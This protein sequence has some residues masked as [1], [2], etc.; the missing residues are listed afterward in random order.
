MTPQVSGPSGSACQGLRDVGSCRR[1]RQLARHR[2][3]RK[4]FLWQSPAEDVQ[5]LLR[6]HLALKIHSFFPRHLHFSDFPKVVH[7]CSVCLSGASPIKS[8]LSRYLAALQPL[9]QQSPGNLTQGC[10]RERDWASL[11]PQGADWY[12]DLRLPVLTCRKLPCISLTIDD[13]GF[14]TN[15]IYVASIVQVSTYRLKYWQ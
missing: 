11:G 6:A 12:T 13:L 5:M 3:W 10:R 9:Q 1:G 7:L 15:Y 4:G 8:V 14:N 2:P